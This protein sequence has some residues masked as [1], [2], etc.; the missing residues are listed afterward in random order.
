MNSIHGTT[1]FFLD[2]EDGIAYSRC[3]VLIEQKATTSTR[4]TR[5]SKKRERQDGAK[6]VPI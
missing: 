1:A 2:W 3:G 6:N 5:P 4:L